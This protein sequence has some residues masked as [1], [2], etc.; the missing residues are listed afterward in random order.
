MTTTNTHGGARPGAG[1][2]PNPDGKR[3]KTSITLPQTL[4]D[5][6]DTTDNRSSTIEGLI[7]KST[8]FRQFVSNRQE[9]TQ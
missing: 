1:A 5:Y 8:G 3:V 4:V 7:R 9:P 2:K 6:L